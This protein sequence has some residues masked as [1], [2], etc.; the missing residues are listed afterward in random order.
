DL[1]AE[2]AAGDMDDDDYRTLKADYTARAAAVI[3]TIESGTDVGDD[4]ADG[5]G[6]SSGGWG[7]RLV[8]VGLLAVIA[9]VRGGVVAQSSG[10]RGGG[11]LT[12]LDVSAASSRLGDCQQLEIESE[13]DEALACYGEILESLPANVGALTFRGWLRVRAFDAEA[14]LD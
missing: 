1:E 7:R 13:L 4:V 2:Y 14:G 6:G 11:G 8:G 9:V 12:G 5:G 3:R 10:R